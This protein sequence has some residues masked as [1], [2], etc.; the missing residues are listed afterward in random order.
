MVRESVID[1]MNEVIAEDVEA[2]KEVIKEDILPLIEY[3]S[4]LERTIFNKAYE[5]LQELE[6][7]EV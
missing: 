7:E 2:M 4:K 5:E 6:E 1:L 3:R